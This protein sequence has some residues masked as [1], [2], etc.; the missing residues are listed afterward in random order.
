MIDIAHRNK[1]YQQKYR[2]KKKA[3]TERIKKLVKVRELVLI[4]SPESR[5]EG[6]LEGLKRDITKRV[7]EVD[8]KI[9]IDGGS[10]Q[11]EMIDD[12]EYLLIL[13]RKYEAEYKKLRSRYPLGVGAEAPT[14]ATQ[15]LHG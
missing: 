15:P 10:K 8:G 9:V 12:V 11:S 7:K 14:S 2:D 5:E 6:F 4:K 3:E 1:I 13:L